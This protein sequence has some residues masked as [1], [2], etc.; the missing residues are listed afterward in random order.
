MNSSQT[1]ALPQTRRTRALRAILLSALA[2]SALLMA[3]KVYFW[4]F[5]GFSDWDDEGYVMI[6]LRS[7][8]QGNTLYDHVYSQ[9]G[10]FYYLVQGSLYTSLHMQVTH[11]AVR[12]IMGFFWFLSAVLCSWSVYRLTRSWIL[13]GAGFIGA[14]KVLQFVTLSPGHP[15]QI[16]AALL[17]AVLVSACYLGDRPSIWVASVLGALIAALALTKINI[18]C[19][20]ALATGLALLKASSRFRMQKAVFAVGSVAGLSLPL[21]LLSPHLHLRWAQEEVFLVVLS[22][23]AAI[24]VVWCSEVEYFVAPSLWIGY[25]MAVGVVPVLIVAL[26]LV[27]GTTLPAMLYMTV[28][29]HKDYATHWYVALRVRTELAALL[30]LLLAVIWVRIPASSQS[31][32]AAIVGLNIIKILV[33]L[34]WLLNITHDA[35]MYN[36]VVPFTWL[37]LTPS[38]GDD[39]KKPPFARVALCLL[40]VFTALYLLPV[41]GAQVGFSVLLTIPMVCVFLNDAVLMPIAISR[42]GGRMRIV[43][44]AAVVV[45]TMV[46]VRSALRAVREYRKLTPIELAGAERIHLDANKAADYQWITASLTNACD[47]NYSMPGIFSLY[48][49]TKTEPPTELLAS[50]WIGLLN[51]EQQQKVAKDLSR[52]QRLCIVYNASLVSFWRRGQDLSASPLA[53]YIR[54]EFTAL[55]ERDGYVVLIRNDQSGR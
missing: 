30:S 12:A 22:V 42:L 27:R 20:V 49:W 23:S 48:F 33:S 34:L 1:A 26:F 11:D 44:V 35:L 43:E 55:A 2:V 39:S 29:Q 54:D 37:V 5:I 45:L 17:F 9:Y 4:S 7:L 21:I 28:L 18:G 15:E 47:S 52:F 14:I 3:V 25:A 51:T 32:R 50:N 36:F 13:T 8:L 40:S 53:R 46:S 24:L 19:Y 31:R 10:P 6:G 16:C 38:I 41:A